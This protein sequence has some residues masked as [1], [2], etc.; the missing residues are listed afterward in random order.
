MNKKSH[1]GNNSDST[2]GKRA[3]I[4][5]LLADDHGIVRDSLAALLHRDDDIEVVAAVADG[6][7]A[8]REAKRVKP[9]IAL[10]GGAFSAPSSL[11]AVCA[12][13]GKA[14]GVSVIILSG[15]SSPGTVRRAFEAGA[16]GYLSKES[17]GEE[18]LKAIRAV[19]AGK[20]YLGQGLA[21][22][23]VDDPRSVRR[24]EQQVERLTATEHKILRLVAEGKSNAEVAELIGLSAR[25]VE[26][27][28]LRLMR[29]LGIGDLASLVKYAI[30]QGI[31]SLE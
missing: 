18:V 12:L 28:R 25:T 20:R 9:R 2:R 1:A 31:T 26:T 15:Q 29:K 10:L 8:V 14:P 7:A 4:S 13:A 19:A 24:G 3:S 23:S 11:D 30:R 27:Y 5:V 21:E 22:E 16:L 17:S 6:A